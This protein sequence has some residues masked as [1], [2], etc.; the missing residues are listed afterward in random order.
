MAGSYN[1]YYS[2]PV[3]EKLE[4]EPLASLPI[5]AAEVAETFSA[6][7]IS[8]STWARYPP[9]ALLKMALSYKG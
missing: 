7:F 5:S 4:L 9:S 2:R 8:P 1:A 6:G 3:P